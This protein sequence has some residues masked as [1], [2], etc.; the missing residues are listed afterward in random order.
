M[1]IDC[2]IDIDNKKMINEIMISETYTLSEINVKV[3]KQVDNLFLQAS[4]SVIISKEKKY[5]G[6]RYVKEKDVNFIPIEKINDSI[7]LLV[8]GRKYEREN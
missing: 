7:L 5:Y 2:L 4:D 1:A 3:P 6:L 8:D